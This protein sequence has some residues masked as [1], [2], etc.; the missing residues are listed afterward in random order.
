MFEEIL[1]FPRHAERDLAHL[2]P[3]WAQ[4]MGRGLWA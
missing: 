1:T 3:A 4:D 2:L